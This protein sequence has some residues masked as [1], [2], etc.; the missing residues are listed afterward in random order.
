MHL[1]LDLHP[2]HNRISIDYKAF[3]WC[4]RG[5]R[6]GLIREAPKKRDPLQDNSPVRRNLDVDT[7]PK[8]EYVQHGFAVHGGLTKIHLNAAHNRRGFSTLEV[9]RG[10][11]DVFSPNDT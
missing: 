2:A 4:V 10:I 3:V 7:S 9:L 5:W 6:H 1:I 8:S 11:L